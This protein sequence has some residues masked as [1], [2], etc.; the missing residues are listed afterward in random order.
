[1]GVISSQDI[2]N[3]N[4]LIQHIIGYD[5]SKGDC[6]TVTNIPFDRTNEFKLEDSMYF[7]QEKIKYISLLIIPFII[8]I[9]AAIIFKIK[10]NL[11]T[12]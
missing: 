2:Y 8:I 6:I 10:H 1:M 5:K 11:Y 12:Q 4:L 7:R 3:T 9:L